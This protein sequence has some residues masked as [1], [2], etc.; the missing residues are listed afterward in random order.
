VKYYIDLVGFCPTLK[1]LER[2]QSFSPVWNAAVDDSPPLLNQ[3]PHFLLSTFYPRPLYLCYQILFLF[4][5]KRN[6]GNSV[7]FERPKM[8]HTGAL[9]PY[10]RQLLAPLPDIV[11]LQP[12]A[13]YRKLGILKEQKSGVRIQKPRL[14]PSTNFCRLDAPFSRPPANPAE[15]PA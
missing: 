1:T 2:L 8:R 7:F 6:T 11:P 12:K 14:A 13:Q 15:N 4:D 5:Q 3:R 9:F 10:S